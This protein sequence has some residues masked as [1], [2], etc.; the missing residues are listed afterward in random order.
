MALARKQQDFNSKE[1]SAISLIDSFLD[2]PKNNHHEVGDRIDKQMV[3]EE[4][5]GYVKGQV[6]PKD[7]EQMWSTWLNGQKAWKKLKPT[8]IAG[9]V[10]R[11]LERI[12]KPGEEPEV[13]VFNMVDSRDDPALMDI[14]YQALFR[15][16]NRKHDFYEGGPFPYEEVTEDELDGLSRMG[17]IYDIGLSSAPDWRIAYLP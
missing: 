9:R 17:Y 12:L 15:K 7:I 4:L 3:M 10:S 2:E 16:L 1:N 5:F 11:G 13:E 6:I 8:R 14:R